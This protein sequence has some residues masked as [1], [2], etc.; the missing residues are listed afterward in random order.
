MKYKVLEYLCNQQM[1]KWHHG[2]VTPLYLY[3]GG[4]SGFLFIMH[5]LIAGSNKRSGAF[6]AFNLKTTKEAQVIS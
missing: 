2:C 3:A 5:N 1:N 4:S 6:K